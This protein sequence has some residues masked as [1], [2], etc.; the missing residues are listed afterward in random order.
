[1]VN[2]NCTFSY[3]GGICKAVLLKEGFQF[4]ELVEKVCT[5]LKTNVE[6]K[7]FFYST[8]R[9]KTKY[10]MLSNEEG[11]TMLFRCNED[12][13]DL[14]VEKTR[15]SQD[16]LPT[17]SIVTNNNNTSVRGTTMVAPMEITNGCTKEM[18]LVPYLLE[19]VND[20]LT[21]KG[22]LFDS[23]DLFKQALM[24]VAASS[25]FSFKYLDNSKAYCRIVC[26]VQ[27]CP[28][29]LTA[30]CDSSGDL[31]SVIGLKNEHIHNALDE[32]FYKSTIA[33]KQVSLLFKKNI[34]EKPAFLLRDI[35]NEFENAFQFH[36]SYKQGW[37]AK[38]QAKEF[39]SCPPSSSFHLLPW[40]C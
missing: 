1:M 30:S 17:E 28:W 24:I 11:V 16:N 3:D 10:V 12:K 2:F 37:R 27:W 9:D 34:L 25:K 14:F 22:Q 36:L 6:D 18:G 32:N 20:I 19:N 39:I 13:V 4:N 31:V 33:A 26:Q 21:G 35:C 38:D 40:M 5:A 23:P 8:K 7:M 15:C 29:K